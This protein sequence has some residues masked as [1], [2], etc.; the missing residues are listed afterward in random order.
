MGRVR[1]EEDERV[2]GGAGEAEYMPRAVLYAIRQYS[3]PSLVRN[4][5]TYTGSVEKIEAP[6]SEVIVCLQSGD[7]RCVILEVNFDDLPSEEVAL[8]N[9]TIFV[10]WITRT[11]VG[12]DAG[13]EDKGGR[14]WKG[15]R[16]SEMVEMRMAGRTKSDVST[17][18]R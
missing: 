14:G 8:W 9:V 2:R 6:V 7:S 12:L 17:D 4:R 11:D 3:V 5:R 18:V 15:R 13:S 16:I 1:A 10:Q